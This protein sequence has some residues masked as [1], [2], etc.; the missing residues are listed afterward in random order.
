MLRTPSL[1]RTFRLAN[2]ACWNKIP[3]STSASTTVTP[4]M[5]FDDF[6]HWS[7]NQM[8]STFDVP[9]NDAMSTNHMIDTFRMYRKET[10]PHYYSYNGELNWDPFNGYID[11]GIG[12]FIERYFNVFWHHYHKK[13]NAFAVDTIDTLI[14]SSG[15]VNVACVFWWLREY[16]NTLYENVVIK[17]IENKMYPN[18]LLN[19]VNEFE[20]FLNILITLDVENLRGDIEKAWPRMRCDP[21]HCEEGYDGTGYSHYPELHLG[22]F[23]Y[24]R[25]DELIVEYNAV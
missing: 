13:D 14:S 11:Y 7:R 24:E 12:I 10:S 1:H 20:A 8:R 5:S 23:W 4:T 18:V 17:Q 16:C 21:D 6:V 2:H 3:L 22:K 25:V 9:V 19:D 15:L